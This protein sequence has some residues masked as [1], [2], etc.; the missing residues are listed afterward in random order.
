MGVRLTAEASTL[1]NLLREVAEKYGDYRAKRIE[2]R[3]AAVY[4]LIR[5]RV[6]EAVTRLLPP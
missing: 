4:S 1:S 3:G 5:K 6:P 2:D